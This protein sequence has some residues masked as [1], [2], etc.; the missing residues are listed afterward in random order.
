MAF[1]VL[2]LMI[3]S[4]LVDLFDGEVGRFG[5]LQDFVYEIGAATIHLGQIS[6]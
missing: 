4:N 2:R 5:A 6:P 1:A 3:S